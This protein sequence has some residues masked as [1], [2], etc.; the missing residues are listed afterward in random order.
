HLAPLAGKAQ[1]LPFPLAL[2]DRLH[3]VVACLA[4]DRSHRFCH[5]SLLTIGGVQFTSHQ[6]PA[7]PDALENGR[8]A[9]REGF[10]PSIRVSPY[11]G[12]ANRWFQ[13][14]THRSVAGKATGAV[15]RGAGRRP[16]LVT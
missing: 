8:L 5:G 13:P 6:S 11:D 4:L 10:E 9:E 14:L 12:L 1:R 7:R 2:V 15:L 16:G 3:R